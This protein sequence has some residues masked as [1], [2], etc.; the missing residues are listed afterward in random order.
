MSS[1][2]IPAASASPPGPSTR[3]ARRRTSRAAPG[4]R[5][6]RR[7][8]RRALPG[9]RRTPAPRPRESGSRRPSAW[10]RRSRGSCRDGRGGRA[11][12][13]GARP[14][15]AGSVRTCS[16]WKLEQLGDQT[17]AGSTA[18]DQRRQGRAELPP[19]ARVEA[20]VARACAPVSSVV[21]RLAVGAGD[22]DERVPGTP[23]GELD[24]APR[25]ARSRRSAA[26]RRL[27]GDPGVLTSRSATSGSVG[28]AEALS[29]AAASPPSVSGARHRRG[30]DPRPPA[31]QRAA[32]PRCGRPQRA[33]PSTRHALRQVQRHRSFEGRGS[34]SRTHRRRRSPRSSRSAR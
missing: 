3:P 23:A 8:A 15:S 10:R 9:R 30:D 13:S 28:R 29:P 4:R 7:P 26:P 31:A 27:A 32:R 33:R 6:G 19:T 24:L 1:A 22:A 12:G 20:R 25:A 14:R 16:S 11:P 34:R 18:P 2:P 5:G 21:V 17:A